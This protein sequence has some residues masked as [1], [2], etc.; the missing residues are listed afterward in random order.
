MKTLRLIMLAATLAAAIGGCST[1]TPD[2]TPPTSDPPKY[3][4][5]IESMRVGESKYTL[6]WV[7]WVDLDGAAWLPTKAPIDFQGGTNTMRIERRDDGYHV[8][9]PSDSE[10]LTPT[11]KSP[12]AGSP[13]LAWL[14]V[15][16][17]EAGP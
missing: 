2:T 4:R 1:P 7:V 3:T 10:Y 8:W 9:L 16:A 15:A 12:Y 5:T 11:D 6:P 14:P 17:I 13:G